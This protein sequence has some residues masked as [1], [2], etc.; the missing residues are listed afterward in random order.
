[1]P[2]ISE[3]QWEQFLQKNPDAHILQTSRWGELKAQYGWIPKWV[4]AGNSGAQILI[5]KIPLGFSFAY[6]PKGPVGNN[7]DQLL[8]EIDRI[9][10]L[11]KTIFLK[12]EP[13]IW[14]DE[15]EGKE[16]SLL[17]G[18]IKS[19]QPIQPTRTIIVDIQGKEDEILA[20]MKQKTR[21]NIRLS[22]RKGVLVKQS[23][24]IDVFFKLIQTTGQRD[25]FSVHSL[26]YYRKAY[27][28]FS[29]DNECVLLIAEHE[30]Q[31][32]AAMMVFARGKTAWYF[33]GASANRGRNLM[34]TYALH[35]EAIRWARA[36]GCVQ[37]DLWGVPNQDLEILEA[38][39]MNRNDG[40]WGVYRHKRG[41][42][43][44]LKQSIGS[45]DRVYK[46]VLYRLYKIWVTRAQRD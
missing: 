13:N 34:P 26:D 37:Y 9:C 36:R 46:P 32:L 43:G 4:L 25:S 16:A 15:L 20:R 30:N 1:M 24:D 31:P 22:F 28:L 33:Y 27:D 12:V 39:F 44:V 35:W 42:G 41:F 11:N 3:I 38:E 45:W 10:E 40:L 29:S 23:D 7:W 2:N 6:I 18:F 19:P 8:S 21:Y 5:K 14:V 17:K